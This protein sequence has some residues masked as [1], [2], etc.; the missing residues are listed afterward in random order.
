ME[1]GIIYIG[2]FATH[3]CRGGHIYNIGL[4]QHVH[5]YKGLEMHRARWPGLAYMGL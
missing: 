5:A 1:R 4:G 3:G 2:L